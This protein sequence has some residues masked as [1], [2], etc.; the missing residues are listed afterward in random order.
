MNA[1]SGGNRGGKRPQAGGRVFP[2]EGEVAE[3]PTITVSGTLPINHLY[4]HVLFYSCA[5]HSFVNPVFAKK[6]TS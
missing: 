1:T 2:L 5:A 4:A 3:D 6:L